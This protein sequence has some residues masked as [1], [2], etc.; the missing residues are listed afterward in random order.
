ME[1]VPIY[2]LDRLIDYV[3]LLG[4]RTTCALV[5]FFLE[6]HAKELFVKAEHLTRLKKMLPKKPHYVDRRKGVKNKLISQWNIIVPLELI[7]RDWEESW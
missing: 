3:Q 6:Q 5:G 2:H 4:K 7:N 1:S